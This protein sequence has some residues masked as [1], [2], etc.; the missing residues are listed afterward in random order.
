MPC[1]LRMALPETR[2]AYLLTYFEILQ[3]NIFMKT[4]PLKSMAS[5]PLKI[6]KGTH[7]VL[8]LATHRHTTCTESVQIVVFSD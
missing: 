4:H 3:H 5:G 8:I 7:P 6:E 2:A 1:F